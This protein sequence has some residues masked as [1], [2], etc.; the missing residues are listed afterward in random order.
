[1]TPQEKLQVL[2]AL[3]A[4]AKEH[5]ALTALAVVLWVLSV[6]WKAVPRET[7]SKLER[8][9]PRATG[10]M[11]ALLMLLSDLVG[12]ARVIVYQVVLGRVR[13]ELEEPEPRETQTPPE[14]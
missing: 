13:P 5:P 1:M 3:Y 2:A 11:R 4:F 10:A 12:A 8:Q 7:R 14:P 6:A 9:Y